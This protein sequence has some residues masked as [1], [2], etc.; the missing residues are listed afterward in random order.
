M[1]TTKFGG[2]M[3]KFWSYSGGV[4]FFSKWDEGVGVEGGICIFLPPSD[5]G[6]WQFK[7]GTCIYEDNFFHLLKKEQNESSWIVAVT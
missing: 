5:G 4:G 6:I 2:G 1:L 3:T 7:D